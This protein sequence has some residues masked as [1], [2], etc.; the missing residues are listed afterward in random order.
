EA[1]LQGRHKLHV[2]SNPEFLREGSGI[3]DFFH[4]DRIVIGADDEKVARKVEDLYSALCLQTYI[5]DIKSAEM[6][7]YA[8]NAFLATKISFINEISNI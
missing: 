5:T 1:K 2:V 4:G 6:I 7:K 8:S 3:Y